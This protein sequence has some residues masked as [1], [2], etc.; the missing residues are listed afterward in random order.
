MGIILSLGLGMRGSPVTL[1]RGAASNAYPIYLPLVFGVVPFQPLAVSKNGTG[2]GSITSSPTGINCGFVCSY[3]FPTNSIITLTAT[4]ST[5]STF[6]GWSG[7]GCSGM[8]TCTVTMD[9]TRSVTAIFTLYSFALIITKSGGGSG[10]VTSS[11]PGIDC[12][13]LCSFPFAYNTVVKLTATSIAPST[14]GGWSGA[15]CSGTGTCTV[16][17]NSA[18]FVTATFIPPCSG[19]VNCDFE[20]GSTAW[21][22]YS[23][24]GYPVI[25]SS[26]EPLLHITPR[27]GIFLAW[28]GN[29]NNEVSYVQQQVTI[30]SSAS[31]LVY[32]QW[33]ES[34]DYCGFDYD[35]AQVLI[36]D[37]PV[38]KYDLCTTTSTIIWVKHSIE[39]SAYAGQTVNLQI[40]IK[41][42]GTKIS[43]LYLDDVSLQASVP[44][45]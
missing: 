6:T 41:T 12:D 40:N 2:S 36:N 22:V 43:S 4:A 26:S 44:T 34:E 13:P 21:T 38:N 32:W 5:G 3:N 1:A 10:T 18:Q 37:K 15:G 20:S 25:Y 35:Y 31:T 8:G 19:I 42:D 30:S 24:L 29:H 17:M 11:P 39:L 9:A 16:T 28:L 27:S 7:S 33:I 14:F 45:P 23:L